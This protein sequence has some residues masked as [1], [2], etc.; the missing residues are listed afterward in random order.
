MCSRFLCYCMCAWPKGNYSP[1]RDSKHHTAAAVCSLA[2]CVTSPIAR[3]W[4]RAATALDTA[5]RR[6]SRRKTYCLQTM[7]NIN[8][9]LVWF[10]H[11][12]LLMITIYFLNQV[13][14]LFVIIFELRELKLSVQLLHI[15]NWHDS[16]WICLSINNWRMM[17]IHFQFSLPQFAC[18]AVFL[19]TRYNNISD[20]VSAKLVQCPFVYCHG[21]NCGLVAS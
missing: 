18:Q 10:S 3:H 9:P 4:S 5:M 20:R 15:K 2:L 11:T 17:H 21:A 19:S 12:S 16:N 14:Y 13:W 1:Q 6:C 7:E 8:Q